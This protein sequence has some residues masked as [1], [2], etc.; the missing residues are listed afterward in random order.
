MSELQLDEQQLKQLLADEPVAAPILS[1]RTGAA[2]AGQ[3]KWTFS[4]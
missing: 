4:G 2:G 3:F 1:C